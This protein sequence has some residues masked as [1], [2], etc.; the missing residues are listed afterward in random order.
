MGYS[1]SPP[2]SVP[3]ITNKQPYTSGKQDE[4]NKIVPDKKAT[5]ACQ[6]CCT[7]S[8]ILQ[9]I[10]FFNGFLFI[11]Y[12]YFSAIEKQLFPAC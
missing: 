7:N 6:V 3:N 2:L 4:Q 10:H 12:Y 1:P 8:A 9:A 11:H 5:I